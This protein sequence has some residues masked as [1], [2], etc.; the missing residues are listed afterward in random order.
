MSTLTPAQIA[1]FQTAGLQHL[2]EEFHGWADD[3]EDPI[4]F[5]ELF[6]FNY[7]VR[8]SGVAD[9]FYY[10]EDPFQG[11]PNFPLVYVYPNGKVVHHN[12]ESFD[13]CYLDNVTSVADF[14]VAYTAEDFAV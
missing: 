2:V 11:C 13:D 12:V 1:A 7:A 8:P 5:A 14:E 9:L 3:G 6:V 10:V 4:A